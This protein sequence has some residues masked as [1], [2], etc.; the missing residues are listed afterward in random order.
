MVSAPVSRA[1]ATA[2]FLVAVILAAAANP[3]WARQAPPP[4]AST[5]ATTAVA[6]TTMPSPGPFTK[7]E[8]GV[9]AGG[10]LFTEAW[11]SNGTHEWIGEGVF[12]V[13]WAFKEGAALVVEFHAAGIAQAKP[14]TAFLNALVPVMRWRVVNRGATTMFWELGAGVSWSDTSGAAARHAL[15]LPARHEPRR[16]APARPPG[17]RRRRRAA[18]ASFQCVV[19]GARPQP[20]HR[21]PRGLRRAALRVLNA[22]GAAA[23][24]GERA[25]SCGPHF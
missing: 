1:L 7:N 8:I 4:A 3:A 11:N 20:G 18:R 24:P 21:G 10:G 17:T 23:R 19:D 13:S 2:V 25:A 22:P 14:R 12:A 16:H 6:A 5:T 9:E 15:Q